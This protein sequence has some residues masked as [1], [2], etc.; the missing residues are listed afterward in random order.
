MVLAALLLAGAGAVFLYLDLGQNA[1]LDSVKT[2][3]NHLLEFTETH[4]ALAVVAFVFIYALQTA[5]SLPGTPLLTLMGGFL[6]GSFHGLFFVTLGATAGAV[7]AF[8]AARYLFRDW[9]E[10][11]FGDWV[12]P[13]QDCSARNAFFYLFAI[14]I[15]P[16][17]PFFLVNFVSGIT[18]IKLDTFVCAT[19]IG[20]LPGAFVYTIAGQ[21]L[22]SINSIQEI[23]SPNVLVALTLLGFLIFAPF[24]YRKMTTTNS[25]NYFR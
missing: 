15:N 7:L 5:L 13:I 4:Y 21:Q 10:T 6:F 25:L 18:K 2:N 22:G 11:R 12:H 23:V 17:I 1:T 8:L 14:R 24:V 9:A 3:R 16:A 19:A 20:I